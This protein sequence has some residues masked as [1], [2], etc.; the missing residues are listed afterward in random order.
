MLKIHDIRESRVYQEAMQEGVEKERARLIRSI[1]KWAA[2]KITP[3]QIAEN[4]DLDLDLVLR[5][6]AKKPS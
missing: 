6:L 4:L 1:P 5:E 3:A 2:L